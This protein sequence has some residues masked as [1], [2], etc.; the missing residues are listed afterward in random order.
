MDFNKKVVRRWDVWVELER[1]HSCVQ[2]TGRKRR[3]YDNG[4]GVY[5]EYCGEKRWDQVRGAARVRDMLTLGM[6]V[7]LSAGI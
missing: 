7:F 4:T 2:L 3:R 5:G 6:C 1:S